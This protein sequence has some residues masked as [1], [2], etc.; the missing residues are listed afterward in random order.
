MEKK[1]YT[2]VEEY[3]SDQPENIKTIL[4]GLRITIKQVVPK[5]EEV[6]SY[7]MPAFKQG[8]VLVYYAANKEHTGFYPTPG[9][10][11]AFAEELAAYKSS[12]GAVQFPYDKK[13]PMAL[14]KKM[15]QYRLED[16]EAKA[17]K[18]K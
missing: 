10:L 4:E 18:K 12:K 17:K 13:I 9:P 6:I 11:K 5:A 3:L 8:S 14:V 7:N 1:K 15:V 16:V 2:T